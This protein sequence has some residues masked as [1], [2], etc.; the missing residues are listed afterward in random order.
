MSNSKH[1]PFC[2]KEFGSPQGRGTHQSRCKEN[3]DR[4]PW[5]GKHNPRYGKKGRNQYTDRDWSLVPYDKL[6][7]SKKRERLIEEA[8]GACTQCGF[9]KTRDCGSSILE[10]DHI[11]GNPK[12]ND[13]SN[14]RVLCPNCHALTDTFRNW[15]NEG[16]K[17]RSPRVRNGNLKHA[18]NAQV[19]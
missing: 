9:S 5:S 16:N 10:I 4:I 15:G 17:K 19:A 13:R 1:C 18:S 6:G 12:N 8:G 3:P 7:R 11:D 14:L 2:K